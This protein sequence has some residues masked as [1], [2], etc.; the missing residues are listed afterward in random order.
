MRIAII[1]I[2]V[3]DKTYAHKVNDILHQYGRYI[4]GRMGLPNV[5]ED[6]NIITLVVK[7]S[8]EDISALSGKLGS[9]KGVISK[10]TYASK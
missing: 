5:E 4:I 2:F 8:Q 1:A 6:L 3:E 7:A 10:V 9:L